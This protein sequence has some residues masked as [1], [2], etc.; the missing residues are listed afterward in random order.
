M[1]GNKRFFKC[2]NMHGVIVP[3]EQ[4]HILVPHDVSQS[5]T[6]VNVIFQLHE[7]VPH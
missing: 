4:V 3:I 5:L 7:E 2:P 6:F 1:H